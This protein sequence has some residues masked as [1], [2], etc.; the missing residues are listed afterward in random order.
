ML[1]YSYLGPDVLGGFDNY[2]YSAKDTSPLSN[3]VC[4]PFWNR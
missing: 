2:K 3:Y 1:W 4:H